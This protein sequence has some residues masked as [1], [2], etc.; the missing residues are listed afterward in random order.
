MIK[1]PLPDFLIVGCMKCGTTTLLHL[2]RHHPQIYIPYREIDYFSNDYLYQRRDIEWYENQFNGSDN[3]FLKFLKNE[4]YYS[5][6][7]KWYEERCQKY[8]IKFVVGEK[9]VAYTTVPERIVKYLPQVKL[10]WI[11]R[12]PISRTYSHYWHSV[13]K[14]WEKYNF[15]K[16]LIKEKAR[17]RNKK[18]NFPKYHFRSASIY[19]KYIKNYLRH[20]T[21]SQMHFI[22]FEDMIENPIKVAQNVYKFLNVNNSFTPPTNIKKN[23]TKVPFIIPLQRL[24]GFLLQTC[25]DLIGYNKLTKIIFLIISQLSELNKKLGK[26]IKYPKINGEIKNLLSNYFQKSVNQLEEITQLDLHKWRIYD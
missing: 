16:G 3:Y 22:L 4:K 5:R 21:R 19:A 25:Y 23:I 7:I 17:T 9:T 20:F 11:F 26:N 1:I 8:G 13:M 15:Y 18:N 10:I 2:L 14:G 12:N 24:F 6:G